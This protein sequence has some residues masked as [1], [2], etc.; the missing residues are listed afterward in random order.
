MAR[1]YFFGMII[2][3][4]VK[5]RRGFPQYVLSWSYINEHFWRYEGR[6]GWT[7][8]RR[9]RPISSQERAEW[10]KEGPDR[11]DWLGDKEGLFSVVSYK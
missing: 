7:W 1:A 4:G 2:G 5:F 11:L 3:W 8:N 9:R 6:L 10:E